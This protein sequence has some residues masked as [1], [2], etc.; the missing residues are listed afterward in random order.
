VEQ[1]ELQLTRTPRA[2]PTLT[3]NRRDSLFDYVF[4][5]V[6]FEGYQP[7]PAIKAEVAV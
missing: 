2:L 7:H 6:A 3:L 5:D 1:A 4:E